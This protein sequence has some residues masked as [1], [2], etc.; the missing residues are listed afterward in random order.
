MKT[1]LYILLL[2]GVPMSFLAQSTDQNYI[3]STTP[4]VAVTDP[5]TLTVANSR[6]AIQY[7]DGLGRPMQTIQKGMS[8]LGADLVSYTEYDGIGR[9]SKQWLPVPIENNQGLSVAY[10][11]F[12]TAA[13]G[14]TLYN[15]DARPYVET[16]YEPS[17]LNRV[18]E[19]FGAGNDWFINNKRKQS[20]YET[21][22]T[23]IPNFYVNTTGNL[24]RG[25]DYAI[26]TLYKT[27]VTDEDGKS[28]TEYKDKL[29]Q[30]IMK[31]NDTD[32][33]TYFV[34]NDLGQL[35]YVLPP[36][37]VDNLITTTIGTP[38]A[39]TNDYLKKYCY[40]YKYDERG[41]CVQ[42]RLPGCEFIY[43]VYDRADRLVLSQDGNQRLKT[44]WTV[45]KYDALGR[46][47]FTGY[48]TSS[49]TQVS[50]KTT[51]ATT[52][53]TESTST[54][55][56]G[57][58]TNNFSTA[59][60][61]IVNYYDNYYFLT[62]TILATYAKFTWETP[63]TGYDTQFSSAKE[64]LTGTR[65]YLLDNS[66]TYLVNVMYYDE[67]GQVVQSK[68]SNHLGGISKRY[69]HYNFDGTINTSLNKQF[70]AL[71]N[72]SL[73]EL[74]T[75]AYD[76]AGRPTF[77]Y[78]KINTKPQITLSENV[79]DELGRLT[80]KKRHA[81]GT[82]TAQDTETYS[83]NIRNWTTAIASGTFTESLYYNK[84]L[85]T[86]VTACYNGNIAYSNWTYNTVN[87]GYAYTY[88]NL[89]RLTDANFKQE[90]S[91][92][93]N[94]SF[95]EY[96]TYDKHGNISTLKRKKDNVLIDELNMVHTGN[97]LSKVNDARGSQNLYNLKEYQD[98]NGC[99]GE[100]SDE[101]GNQLFYD[102]NG[103]LC[104]DFDRNI[105]S[106]KYNIL[107]LPESIWYSDGSQTLNVYDA[108]GRKLWTRDFTLQ[109]P[110]AEPLTDGNPYNEYFFAN[111]P[112]DINSVYEYRTDYVDNVEFKSQAGGTISF[113]NI[114][115]VS[116]PEGY[117]TNCMTS[118]DPQYYYYRKDHLG[119]IREV[120][121][122]SY[123]SSSG[124][125][126]AASTT[127]RTQYYPSGLPWYEGTGASTQA[128]KYNAKEFLEMHGYDTFDYGARGMY[129]AIGSFTS[130]DP[131][132]EK[133]YS[134]SPYAYCAGN[135]V[136]RIDP[137]GME[138][139]GW[140]LSDSKWTYSK[141]VTKD[142]YK[143][144]GFS[145]FVECGST[146]ENVKINN[147]R[148]G[149]VYFGYS[150]NDISYSENTFDNWY[151]VHSGGFSNRLDAY[152]SWQS[153]PFQHVGES[154]G[155]YHMR[156]AAYFSY[157]ERRDF[158]GGGYHMYS[159]SGGVA[160]AAKSG[161]TIIGEGMAR[162]QAAAASRSGSVILNTMPEFTGSAE[163][164]TSQMM[165]Y[166][167]Q[168][169]LNEM[170]SGRTIFDIGLDVNRTNPS[171]FY[172][173]EQNMIKNY[174]ILHPSSLNIIKP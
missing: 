153:S 51:Y 154:K 112:Y 92:Q 164:V 131:L 23:V 73:N 110:L 70:N 135:P 116:N 108:S 75:Y 31:Q 143:D 126:I 94:G 169:I 7:L 56:Y 165:Q 58:T 21:N 40:L 16:K 168:W 76:A 122:A 26:A 85:P 59:T 115:R 84:D 139:E 30:V 41:N 145:K 150:Q 87:K 3:I 74:Y 80:T 19:V 24:V 119:S 107:N 91:L 62:S 82:G 134:I 79:Y 83:Y 98:K 32:V 129:P 14:Q 48:I 161:T 18:T 138:M 61:L 42:K 163:Q 36:L 142:N 68:S 93:V 102:A 29:G 106:I 144:L 99:I 71:G 69:I 9:Q 4:T 86:G 148:V 140:G 38:I 124:T 88:D 52:L 8:P 63:P 157:S 156:L 174:Q 141:D 167:R 37:A 136:N 35:S 113:S 149:D 114:S 103:N 77:T 17:P 97:Q 151:A 155:D 5:S 160:N 162:V 96:F 67:K 28:V 33:K 147:G 152:K 57:Y 6:T 34:Y 20:S 158:A 123:V 81:I 95:D 101:S 127:Q 105:L 55:G 64:L 43:M 159:L 120:W 170:R 166:N 146:V 10:A 44:Q 25:T 50:Y 137:N 89:N 173:M 130:V 47:I 54:S 49:T 11:T 15:S 109:M 172:Q 66:N 104:K 45:T 39:D 46:V 12:K 53:V 128:Y 171:I 27:V 60:P 22:A 121:R 72:L 132:A 133:Y 2:L 78:Y 1:F 125:T 90:T 117:T 13:T 111:Y 100:Y 118:Y 65:T